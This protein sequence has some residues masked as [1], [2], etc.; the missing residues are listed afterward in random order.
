MNIAINGFGRIG[1][2]VFKSLLEKKTNIKI[3]A[4]NDLTDPNTL[5]NLL[6]RDSAYGIYEKEVK[7]TK[8]SLIVGGKKFPILAQKDPANLPWEQMGID[9]VLECTGIFRTKEQAELHLKAGAKKVVISA[10]AKGDEKVKTIVLGV[11]EKDIKK[12]D[13]VISMASCT[14]NCLA[15]TTKV[16]KD[17]FGVKKA[18]MTTIHAYTADQRIVDGPHKDLRRARAAAVNIV[19]TTTGAAIATTK[20]IPSLKDKFDGMA[21]RVPI[22]VGSLT[23]I[24]FVTN[25]NVDPDKI[26]KAFKKASRSASLKNILE[27]SDDPLVSSDIVGNPAS[28]IV[29]LPLTKVIDKNLVKVVAWYDNEWGYSSRMVDLAIYLQ[30]KKLI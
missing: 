3:K 14:T 18:V 22:L 1:R 9:L 24:V 28:A 8:D 13:K 21:V 30:K 2:A 29:D 17:N 27:V 25:K 15:P 10:P 23:D 11:N 7:A 5:A 6:K 12:A 19:P 26:N 16:M 4:I 20:T